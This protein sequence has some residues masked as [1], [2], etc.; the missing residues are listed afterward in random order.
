MTNDFPPPPKGLK[1]DAATLW[2][3]IAESYDLDPACFRYLETA[4]RAFASMR[5]AEALIEKDGF[6]IV[7]R[8]GGKKSHPAHDLVRR[9]R[10]QFLDCMRALNLDIIPPLPPG[11]PTGKGM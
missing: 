4:C 7:D 5:R 10:R 1:G 11:R 9:Y 3:E 2:N 8:Y 6:M